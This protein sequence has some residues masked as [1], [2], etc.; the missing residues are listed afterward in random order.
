MFP[1]ASGRGVASSVTMVGLSPAVAMGGLFSFAAAL[2]KT[3]AGRRMCCFEK[4]GSLPRS[5][6]KELELH[7][8]REVNRAENYVEV[9]ESP[10]PMDAW[11]DRAVDAGDGFDQEPRSTRSDRWF[12]IVLGLSS[13][14]VERLSQFA[15]IVSGLQTLFTR[16]GLAFF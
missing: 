14:P 16:N 13:C 4:G 9:Q 7:G 1:V 6:R 10:F 3:N 5:R 12:A 15:N 11:T 2:G 8:N